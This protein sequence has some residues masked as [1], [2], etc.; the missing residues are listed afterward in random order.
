ME[1]LEEK[2]SAV[3]VIC[4]VEE[5]RVSGAGTEESM[6]GRKKS[7]PWAC[8]TW[9]IDTGESIDNEVLN[10]NW[11]RADENSRWARGRRR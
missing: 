8:N 7:L 1:G 10:Q 5:C 4:R 3:V 9:E 11:S 2:E 6:E